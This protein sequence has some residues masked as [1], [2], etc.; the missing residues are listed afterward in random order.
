MKK[1][2]SAQDVANVIAKVE[3]L[4]TINAKLEELLHLGSND[5]KLVSEKRELL[6]DLRNYKSIAFSDLEKTAIETE[7]DVEAGL[8]KYHFDSL[9]ER[10]KE[11]RARLQTEIEKYKNGD[12]N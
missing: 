11:R 1:I 4:A 3:E 5:E 10:F 8:L 6:K 2:Y 12:T 9:V 7:M